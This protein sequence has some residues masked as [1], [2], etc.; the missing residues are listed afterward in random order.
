MPAFSSLLLFASLR[1]LLLI[2]PTSL[3]EAVPFPQSSN[4][5]N[6]SPTPAAATYWLSS[7]KR[8]GTVAYGDA[9][10]KIFRNV[11]DFG[12]AGMSSVSIPFRS[13]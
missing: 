11:R 13:E 2:A 9:S 7:I 6:S 8:Q 1:L 3:V 12:A 10:F 5:T 4:L